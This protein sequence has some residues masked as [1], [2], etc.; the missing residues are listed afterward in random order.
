MSEIDNEQNPV[1]WLLGRPVQ[2]TEIGGEKYIP[3]Q[4]L[5]EMIDSMLALANK[6]VPETRR[7]NKRTAMDVVE[8]SLFKTVASSDIQ[9]RVFTATRELNDFLNMAITG[10]QPVV[11]SAHT[12]LLPIGHPLSTDTTEVSERTLALLKSEWISADPRISEEFRPLVASICL[13]SPGSVEYNYLVTRLE[14]A[15]VED[16]PKDVV[17]A[18]TAAINPF[19][20][21]NSFLE[22][23]ARAKLQRRD[24][25]GRFA[26]M[27]GGAR[28]FIKSVNGFIHSVIGRF[29]GTGTDTNTFDVEFIDDPVLGTGIYRMP[30]SSVAGVKAYINNLFGKLGFRKPKSADYARGY[31]ID[32]K[33]LV[34]IDAPNGWSVDTNPLDENATFKKQFISTDGYVLR[35]YDNINDIPS[36]KDKTAD[37]NVE[38]K[39]IGKNGEIDPK[40]PVYELFSNPATASDKEKWGD[41]ENVF[42]GYYQSWGD[43]QAAAQKFDKKSYKA[44]DAKKER[45]MWGDAPDGDFPKGVFEQVNPAEGDTPFSTYRSKNNANGNGGYTVRRFQPEKHSA[46]KSDMDKNVS[47]GVEVRGL[48]SGSRTIDPEEPIFEVTRQPSLEEQKAGIQPDVI[49]YAQDWEDVQAMAEASELSSPR[50]KVAKNR[51][52]KKNFKKQADL[53]HVSDDNVVTPDEFVED[54]KGRLLY[55]PKDSKDARARITKDYKGNYVTEIYEDE[56]DQN[57]LKPSKVLTSRTKEEA[58]KEASKYLTEENNVRKGEPNVKAVIPENEPQPE[59]KRSK[60]LDFFKKKG[61][62]RV[63]T[64]IDENGEIHEIPDVSN[65]IGADGKR[66]DPSLLEWYV[67]ENGRRI[68]DAQLQDSQKIPKNRRIRDLDKHMVLDGEGREV[69][70][71][72]EYSREADP[73]PDLHPDHEDGF[74]DLNEV[75]KDE[76]VTGVTDP[77]EAYE[78]LYDGG[79]IEVD[80]EVGL[81]AVLV[82]MKDRDF[83][84]QDDN[85]IGASVLARE[86]SSELEGLPRNQVNRLRRAINPAALNEERATE[87]LNF[88]KSK[89]GEP[90]TPDEMKAVTRKYRN[91]GVDLTNMKLIGTSN[92]LNNNLGAERGKMPQLTTPED[93]KDFEATL[94]K[95]GIKFEP[96]VMTPDQLTPVQAEM[97]MGNV[98]KIMQSWLSPELRA[99]FKMDD[100]V[101]YVTRDGYVIDGHHRWASAL[102]AQMEGGKP[103]ELKCVVVDLDHEDAL[104]ICNEYNDHIGVTRQ[105]LGATSPDAK[106]TPKR[107]VDGEVGLKGNPSFEKDIPKK[108][109]SEPRRVTTTPVQAP[110]PP[111]LTPDIL[112]T[113][114]G[115]DELRG[116]FGKGFRHSRDGHRNTTLLPT[117]EEAKEFDEWLDSV[118]GHDKEV[119]GRVL[120]RLQKVF[121]KD[122]AKK[123]MEHTTEFNRQR[124]IKFAAVKELRREFKRRW[125]TGEKERARGLIE[126]R[127][128]RNLLSGALK[129]D[130]PMSD[131]QFINDSVN[132]QLREAESAY[133]SLANI[134]Q[135][136][137]TE[138]DPNLLATLNKGLEAQNRSKKVASELSFMETELSRGSREEY[139]KYLEEQGVSFYSGDGKDVCEVR[140]TLTSVEVLNSRTG[141]IV[142][143][144]QTEDLDATAA[145]ENAMKKALANYPDWMVKRL[146]GVVSRT[147]AGKIIVEL[148]HNHHNG[149]IDARGFFQIV[150]GNFVIRLSVNNNRDTRGLDRYEE[151]ATHELGHAM[152][153]AIP[154]IREAEWKF[155]TGRTRHRD[156]FGNYR[157]DSF[158]ESTTAGNPDADERGII[159][160]FRNIYMSREYDAPHPL[161]YYEIWS[162][163]YESMIGGGTVSLDNHHIME[164]VENGQMTPE[165]AIFGDNNTAFVLGF[166]LE[167]GKGSLPLQ[168]RQARDGTVFERVDFKY[169]N[170]Q[171]STSASSKNNTPKLG[172]V[173]NSQ[174]LQDQDF[175]PDASQKSREVRSRIEDITE[176]VT[177]TLN[178]YGF[179][180]VTRQAIYRA[181]DG[182]IYKMYFRETFNA[183][184][185]SLGGGVDVTTFPD[186]GLD[187]GTISYYEV[188]KVQDY[189]GEE[190]WNPDKVPLWYD[191]SKYDVTKPFATISWIEVDEEHT[192]KGVGTA[193]LEFSRMSSS[194]PIHHSYQLLEDGKRFARAVQNKQDLSVL[195]DIP[196]TYNSLVSRVFASDSDAAKKVRSRI[197]YKSEEPKVEEI[198]KFQTRKTWKGTYT[199]ESGEEY[200]IKLV[201]DFFKEDDDYVSMM[202]KCE[203]TKRDGDYPIGEINFSDANS[204]IELETNKRS[205]REYEIAEDIHLDEVNKY[206]PFGKIDM[207]VVNDNHRR[208]GIATAMLE[209]SRMN[210]DRPIFHSS[211]RTHAG[212]MFA[213]KIQSPVATDENF[214]TEE[215]D[216]WGDPIDFDKAE[217]DDTG[218]GGEWYEENGEYRYKYVPSSNKSREINK[219]I[220]S[221]SETHEGYHL[222]YYGTYTDENGNKYELHQKTFDN[223]SPTGTI[224][225]YDSNG[226]KVGRLE[227]R[228]LLRLYDGNWNEYEVPNW[229]PRELY[230]PSQTAATIGYITVNPDHQRR[231][232]ATAM[233]EFA[234]RNSV[235]PIHHSSDLTPQ[236]KEFARTVQNKNN[237]TMLEEFPEETQQAIQNSYAGKTDKSKEIAKRIKTVGDIEESDSEEDGVKEHYR[238]IKGEYTT[239]SGEKFEFEIKETF[240]TQESAEDRLIGYMTVY[241]DGKSCGL[242]SWWSE[243]EFGGKTWNSFGVAKDIH[244]EVDE[245]KPFSVIVGVLVDDEHQR[246]GVATAML[247]FARSHSDRPIYH[248]SSRTTMGEAFSLSAQNKKKNADE[249]FPT[250]LDLRDSD[251]VSLVGDFP[252]TEKTL[253]RRRG[254]KGIGSIARHGYKDEN[255]GG[256]EPKYDADGDAIYDHLYFRAIDSGLSKK[257][258][259]KYAI[260]S[261][262]KIKDYVQR[263]NDKSRLEHLLDVSTNPEGASES[264]LRQR[265][266]WR[267]RFDGNAKVVKEKLAK[268]LS[269]GRVVSHMDYD[270]LKKAIQKEESLPSNGFIADDFSTGRALLETDFAAPHS[271]RQIMKD[272][273]SIKN[274]K[275]KNDVKIVLRDSVKDRTT[276]TIGDTLDSG[277][278]PQRMSDT[279]EEAMIKAGLIGNANGSFISISGVGS[280]GTDER[281]VQTSTQ[282]RITLD[283]VDAIY[284]TSEEQL[285]EVR[286]LLGERV[287]DIKVENINETKSF[288]SDSSFLASPRT[289]EIKNSISE[290]VDDF[291]VTPTGEKRRV[292]QKVAKVRKRL[293][294]DTKPS[295]VSSTKRVDGSTSEN[296]EG[297]GS[298]VT[299]SGD[300]IDLVYEQNK[301]T[302]SNGTVYYNGLTITAYDENYSEIGTLEVE[303][304][305]YEYDEDGNIRYSVDDIDT[306]SH[307]EFDDKEYSDT[308]LA[309]ISWIGVEEF[310]QREGIGTAMLEFARDNFDQPIYHSKQLS[311]AGANFARSVRNI[312]TADES[313]PTED[314][315]IDPLNLDA[316]AEFGNLVLQETFK[317][318]G[319]FSI[320]TSDRKEFIEQSMR[321]A[322]LTDEDIMAG[323]WDAKNS[324]P[325]TGTKNIGEIY[326]IDKNGNLNNL[327]K[328]L[329]YGTKEWKDLTQI[330]QPNGYYLQKRFTYEESK[331]LLKNLQKSND[332]YILVG[333]PETTSRYL[334]NA[335]D[336]I[337]DTWTDDSALNMAYLKAAR[338]EFGLENTHSQGF[339]GKTIDDPS[340]TN[341]SQQ[342]VYKAIAR[343]QYEYTQ[344]KLKE[345]GIKKVL[346]YRGMNLPDSVGDLD[347]QTTVS[348]DS[349]PLSSWSTS[350]GVARYFASMVNVRREGEK[351]SLI[352]KVVP[353]EEIF[354]T[355][356]T[357]MGLKLNNE[358]VNESEVVL[359]GGRSEVQA[360]S[361]DASRRTDNGAHV[362]SPKGT[363]EDFPEPTSPN[364]PELVPDEPASPEASAEAAA[365]AEIVRA[366]I[367]QLEPEITKN[368]SSIAKSVGGVLKSLQNRLKTTKSLARKIDKDALDDHNGDRSKAAESISDGIRFT[369]VVNTKNYVQAIKEARE[370]FLALGYKISKEKNN[371]KNESYKD[372]SMKLITPDGMAVEFQIHT[373]ESYEIKDDLHKIYEELRQLDPNTKEAENLR[374]KLKQI[375]QNIPIPEDEELFEMGTLINYQ[376]DKEKKVTK[377]GAS[378]EK[379]IAES[380]PAPIAK[381]AQNTAPEKIED[382]PDTPENTVTTKRDEDIQELVD[383]KAIL[384]VEDALASTEYGVNASRLEF[385]AISLGLGSHPTRTNEFM[386]RMWDLNKQYLKKSLGII[387]WKIEQ[388]VRTKMKNKGLSDRAGKRAA[389]GA[390]LAA[391]TYAD[392]KN[393]SE[394]IDKIAKPLLQ[395]F[396][397][398]LWLGKYL[399]RALVTRDVAKEKIK[400]AVPVIAADF[401]SA[402]N[403]I[404][405]KRFKTQW[406]TGS[407]NGLYS[408]STREKR[409]F[410]LLGIE[411]NTPRKQRPIYGFLAT[412]DTETTPM[413]KPY[414][415]DLF[416]FNNKGVGQYG[417][418]RF[419]LKPSTRGRTTFTMQDSLDV[420]SLPQPLSDNP[421]DEQLDMAGF[422]KNVT[423][424]HDGFFREQYI[425][426]Q[427]TGGVSMDD[428]DRIVVSIPYY[429]DYPEAQAQLYQ[430][431]I[432]DLKL[433]L[434]ASGYGHIQVVGVKETAS[435]DYQ[436]DAMNIS[437]IPL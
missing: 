235:A 23:S 211:A 155:L 72:P 157:A 422:W 351:A 89:N 58:L 33:S 280:P 129:N 166:M 61:T 430:R 80:Q 149:D 101:L 325:W 53:Y 49:G 409:E 78:I 306:V 179:T 192:R 254:Q 429:T 272:I 269:R 301:I 69:K 133:L 285:E 38:V 152:E 48:E 253:K 404:N 181:P 238:K 177:T 288:D 34:K 22:R 95:L 357:G 426:A 378:V 309:G 124:D 400:K 407:S 408:P 172:M 308:P 142:E 388:Q 67:D 342:K 174:Q 108:E 165:E 16:V 278:I 170:S 410:G 103:V 112:E 298:Y 118:E 127:T 189:T 194:M 390:L 137:E 434:E 77:Q 359:L 343:A 336:R 84:G 158:F 262:T 369:M 196:D 119:K 183:D 428:V 46:V 264:V 418:V 222:N 396:P 81:Q 424:S 184:G 66:I 419:V 105:T 431:R 365:K 436:E 251:I 88:I 128:R 151:T 380:Q 185:I 163:S 4:T 367:E 106:A 313:F 93:Q 24:R 221:D 322:G 414:N 324:K 224:Y 241:K 335:I 326:I 371:W 293:S 19:A 161:D 239:P 188:D 173:S 135:V 182:T 25:L 355:A 289:R 334:R 202:G 187:V 75:S 214:P 366:R 376:P 8:R 373:D 219:R 271:V 340:I 3:G 402:I 321:D 168:E 2:A 384:S 162:M 423:D 109:S 268:A 96:K 117:E 85:P 316:D 315:E 20:G 311:N 281:H 171:N 310:F 261:V 230:D 435:E 57:K 79:F 374:G 245:S 175:S 122:F 302:R 432:N 191:K 144:H 113:G 208:K 114:E 153:A 205:W 274:P 227:Y 250:G 190:I 361:L 277:A 348:I 276:Y 111:T 377:Y 41:G 65:V 139:K 17:I 27:G 249:D 339:Q 263:G 136:V 63:P 201:Q 99:K 320:D 354:S 421:T 353:V 197:K 375:A 246:K 259:R 362:F 382:F 47:D 86:L 51:P 398:D 391:K 385:D 307:A 283:D 7:V 150:D 59:R 55:T 1:N 329:R 87:L 225:A 389:E 399:K 314:G 256:Y 233:L 372:Y 94:E 70:F 275:H 31:A 337:S 121:G 297:R 331:E 92:Y 210:S 45:K 346:V 90:L 35:Q 164:A 267:K 257:D 413:T 26:F 299:E 203:I 234:R 148:D 130:T 9:H 244:G 347:S 220:S 5:S 242:L 60:I 279:D 200:D 330:R 231:G 236:G 186:S 358:N 12:D 21:G 291:P 218:S 145:A 160:H 125:E 255:L 338:D 14:S 209:F 102:L 425:E 228:E 223:G 68:P 303:G 126:Q 18:I 156:E 37:G 433:E 240:T 212:D 295:V 252:V 28:A 64:T 415:T 243:P 154:E 39:G 229:Y 138:K 97:D 394:V 383:S 110:P 232:V 11:A 44:V 198:S 318:D 292:S 10:H 417:D 100:Q 395:E 147:P 349:R 143:E 406:E 91:M 204:S 215:L 352:K 286:E 317:K 120:K 364:I 116:D 98:G 199:T 282:G 115:I 83:I 265:A 62:E 56:D 43:V 36:F 370:R 287:K 134:K 312:A 180:A 237:L 405:S 40:H 104:R 328:Y 368:I 15:E 273:L 386:S 132:N 141:H 305:D 260:D 29:V 300:I 131:E 217:D 32:E 290:L 13:T 401:D 363:E 350:T 403:I 216:L 159:D 319:E 146:L 247:E 392:L 387:D 71:T 258:A 74:W 76:V 213:R 140:D 178:D 207:V 411:P 420:R 54:E 397:D 193:I 304:V 248:S 416:A 176:P 107:E 206:K 195:E 379:I 167:G 42:I 30:T 50:T 73:R 169:D 381:S 294:T 345:L 266:S 82:A 327:T 344:K 123:F 412:D 437:G 356:S 52:A 341:P 296:I 226:K 6:D 284:V 333:E 270:K 427:V 332:S 360:I 393:F 323:L